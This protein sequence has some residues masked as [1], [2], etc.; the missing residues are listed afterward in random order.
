MAGSYVNHIRNNLNQALSAAYPIAALIRTQNGETKGFEELA[1]EML[2]LYPGLDA[3]Q[4]H[5]NGI[6]T[7]VVPLKEL[8]NK[9]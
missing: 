8:K 9:L 6:L 3:L 5:K 4:L 2:S 7:H 1:S